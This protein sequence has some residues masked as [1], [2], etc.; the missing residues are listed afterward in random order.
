MFIPKIY[1][2]E[3]VTVGHPDK[4][5]DQISDAILDAVLQ[6]D[7][8]GRVAVEVL[9]GH[10]L[11]VIIGEVSAR[12]KVDYA[13][14]ARQVYRQIGYVDELEIIA[15]VA[16]QSPDIALGVDVGGAG[17]QGMMYG[18]ATAETPQFLP[19][20][21]VLA[22][23]LT[24][25][26]KTLRQDKVLP[27]L[28][29]DG[30]SQVT[31]VN[32]RVNNVLVSA[33]QAAE[34]GSS[35]VRQGLIKQLIQPLLA[36]LTG[37]EILINPTGRFEQGGFSADTGLTGRKI[38]VDTYGGLLPHG[39]GAFSGKDPTKVDRSAAYFARFVAKNLVANGYGQECLV[40][41]A[42]AIGQAAPVMLS[43]V[44][45]QGRD[46]TVVVKNNFDFRPAAIIERLNL[47]R[48]L[49]LA[50]A[51]NGHFSNPAFPWEQLISL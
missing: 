47:R 4:I 24:A 15:R 36:D 38:M 29:P 25:G 40:A 37:V 30:K 7:P 27:W 19:R 6:Q 1:A 48:P 16:E 20:A 35:E 3:S 50:T 17:D 31:M 34:V 10:N 26:L 42:Y 18:F 51:Q 9:G 33:Q 41:V 43:A 22:H 13:E 44:N 2:C 23:Q 8:A 45:E 12:A 32:G 49:Y 5:C 28:L 21:L 11:L 39:G 14:L 46:L